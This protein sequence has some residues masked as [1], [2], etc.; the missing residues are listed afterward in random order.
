M[1]RSPAIADCWVSEPSTTAP[2]ATVTASRCPD[3]APHDGFGPDPDAA[4]DDD[5]VTTH[6]TADD[7]PAPQDHDR[8]LDPSV[9]HHATVGHPDVVDHLL[10]PDHGW[11]R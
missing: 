1:L 6:R 4:A 10:R 5:D 9:D 7:G 11:C 3:V 2:S 8:A